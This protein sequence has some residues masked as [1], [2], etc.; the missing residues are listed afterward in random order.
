[1]EIQ[2]LRFEPDYL[3]LI[4]PL[5]IGL[6]SIAEIIAA[7]AYRTSQTDIKPDSIYNFELF[8]TGDETP[9][10]DPKQ[11]RIKK[12][13]KAG[14][15]LPFDYNSDSNGIPP[16]Y[17]DNGDGTV[18]LDNTPTVMPKDVAEKINFL[19]SE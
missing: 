5:K 16:Y 7:Y 10:N 6:F 19:G 15:L 2:T 12:Y 14:V 18:T 4:R 17:Y 8:R 13:I 11:T 3:R 9:S 1:M